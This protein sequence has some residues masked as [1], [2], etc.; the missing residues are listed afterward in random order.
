MQTFV[1]SRPRVLIVDDDPG[2]RRLVEL[3]LTEDGYTVDIA[4][5]GLDA[6]ERVRESGQEYDLII[7]DL[8]MPLMD[9]RTYFRELRAL[10]SRTP[11]MLL[12]AFGAETAQRELGAEAAL[13][14]PFDPFVL[15]E[16]VR[17]LFRVGLSGEL[18]DVSSHQ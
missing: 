15:S 18:P 10:S 4:I 12:S 17:Q 2:I 6:L 1:A 9:G 5:D 3:I 8:S 14:K 16:R 13:A 11:V 7:L